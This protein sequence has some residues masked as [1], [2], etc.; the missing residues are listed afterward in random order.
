MKEHIMSNQSASD[1]KSLNYQQLRKMVECAAS[2]RDVPAYIVVADG[3]WTVHTERPTV[4]EGGALIICESPG[5]PK[6]A[7]A[8]E[9]TVKFARIGLDPHGHDPDK[10]A[11]LLNLPLKE[12]GGGEVMGPA[13][14]VFWSAAA[15]EKFLVPYYAS[16]YGDQ[17][18][19]HLTGLINLLG[20]VRV[21]DTSV[22]LT[23]ARGANDPVVF[24]IAHMPKSEYVQVPGDTG[25]VVLTKEH[26]GTVK[27]T[28]FSE[29]VNPPK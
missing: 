29:Y 6:G 1:P 24:A 23:E 18:P 10:T 19:K 25:M 14:A 17:A 20:A 28:A 3:V 5:K 11:D 15:V 22:P 21:D 13:D 4:P 16:V 2:Y 8:P 12:K 26:D 9:D 27:A 7:D